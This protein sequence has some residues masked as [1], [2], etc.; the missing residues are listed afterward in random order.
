[1]PQRL[2]KEIE[3]IADG[4]RSTVSP[5]VLFTDKGKMAIT[6]C[7]GSSRNIVILDDLQ[8]NGIFYVNPALC[9]ALGYTNGSCDVDF[10]ILFHQPD[11]YKE[12]SN[13]LKHFKELNSHDYEG[14]VKLMRSDGAWLHLFFVSRLLSGFGAS[15]TAVLTL[16]APCAVD[17]AAPVTKKGKLVVQTSLHEALKKFKTLQKEKRE[18][19]K[20]LAQQLKHDDIALKVHR[21]K[22]AVEKYVREL[23][24]LFGVNT[25]Y[26][27]VD[28]YRRY[29]STA[30]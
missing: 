19:L 16:M 21:G 22:D 27:L 24:D 8:T 17:A 20:Y 28:I 30:S 6:L 29:I 9:S 12:Y 14:T 26:D 4:L 18:T 13:Y 10:K 3:L 5:G 2:K 25:V 7:A 1:M 23:K 11:F 15:G